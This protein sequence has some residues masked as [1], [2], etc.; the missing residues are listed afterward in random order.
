MR[1]SGRWSVSG[2]SAR[3]CHRCEEQVA[4]KP[5]AR[6]C[7]TTGYQGELDA[8]PSSSSVLREMQ[9]SSDMD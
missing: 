8:C 9:A 3:T 5:H 1:D 7:D 2:D 4:A 6:D